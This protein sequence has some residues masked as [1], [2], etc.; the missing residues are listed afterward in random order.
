MISVPEAEEK[1]QKALPVLDTEWCSYAQCA[2]RI[3][4]RSII[5]DRPLPPYPRVMM[6]G[7]AVC[8]GEG[9][10]SPEHGW[11]LAGTAYAGEPQKTL[12]D[13]SK[14]MKVMTGAVLP[15]GADSVIPYEW[16]VAGEEQ[17]RLLPD[18]T[19][20]AGQYVH[21]RGS[22]YPRGAVL[23]EA[24]RPLSSRELAVAVSNG[25]IELEVSRLPQLALIS[26]GDELVEPEDTPEPHQIRRSNTLAMQIL[27]ESRHLGQVESLHVQDQP[28]AIRA[29]LEKHLQ[30]K[31]VLVLSGGV[32]KGEKDYFPEILEQLGVKKFFHRVAQRPGKPF[33]FGKHARGTLVFAFPGNPVSSL[34]GAH[35]YLLPALER[36][37]ACKAKAPKRV[38]LRQAFQFDPPPTLF[39]PVRL[40]ADP[41]TGDP[42][43]LPCPVSNSGDYAS[44][45]ATDGFIELPAERNTFEAGEGFPFYPWR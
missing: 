26:S 41:D 45:V 38:P 13:S 43:A 19:L 32:S 29:C 28:D 4:R 35:R 6:D 17:I 7:Y 22:D 2:G 3:L 18:P 34:V 25:K 9:K 12:E 14:A 11:N 10:V 20:S 5:A 33:W 21:A 42:S 40:L 36:M 31:D 1:I 27:V 24:R 44:L 23:V 39:L 15:R 37:M 16:V 8:L 30:Q